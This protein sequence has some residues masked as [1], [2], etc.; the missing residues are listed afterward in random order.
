MNNIQ[1]Y[2][3]LKS[4]IYILVTIFQNNFK[5]HNIQFNHIFKS[6]IYIL[7]IIIYI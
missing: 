4:I 2:I 1:F 5:I 6:I 7:K 3:T